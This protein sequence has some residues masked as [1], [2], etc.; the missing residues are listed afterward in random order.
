MTIQIKQILT[1]F[2][3]SLIEPYNN[4]NLNNIDSLVKKQYYD[5]DNLDLYADRL[6][7]IRTVPPERAFYN[8]DETQDEFNK[9]VSKF[10]DRQL[11]INRNQIDVNS[12][13]F[14]NN[15]E[16]SNLANNA[17]NVGILGVGLGAAGVGLGLHN[18]MKN[19]R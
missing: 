6:H 4:E 8:Q 18:H 12:D 11:K 2:N 7:D 19:R 3:S 5:N 15:D 16:N 10:S 13:L 17:L 14:K 1:E 9:S